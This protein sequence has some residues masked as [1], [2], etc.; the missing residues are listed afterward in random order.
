MPARGT[1][2]TTLVPEVG[3]KGA[4]PQQ[5]KKLPASETS[6]ASNSADH[7]CIISCLAVCMVGLD[8]QPLS[9]P[10]CRQPLRVQRPAARS[11]STVP[12]H[13]VAAPSFRRPVDIAMPKRT[14]AP[15]RRAQKARRGERAT[16]Y[17]RFHFSSSDS[18]S[19]GGAPDM[20]WGIEMDN[21]NGVQAAAS[22]DARAGDTA[23]GG[24][25]RYSVHVKPWACGRCGRLGLTSPCE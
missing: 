5:P 12:V 1:R 3:G 11:G 8:I 18:A 17:D 13:W 23:D 10:F 24:R 20:D 15:K 22:D 14:G 9:Q 7:F 25:I 19:S 4:Q 6:G 2:P 16:S 21:P